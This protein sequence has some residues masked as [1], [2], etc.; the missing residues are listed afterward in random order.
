MHKFT[1]IGL[2]AIGSAVQSL[3]ADVCRRSRSRD[4]APRFFPAPLFYTGQTEQDAAPFIAAPDTCEKRE[5]SQAGISHRFECTTLISNMFRPL[6]Q[7][8]NVVHLT[9]SKP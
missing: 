5:Q 4:P 7:P 6:R 3:I 9:S 1:D 8:K 2:T